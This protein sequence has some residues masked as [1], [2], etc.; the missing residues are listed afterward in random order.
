MGMLGVIPARGGSKG[1]RR[2]NLALLGGRPLIHYTLDAAVASGVL[3]RVIVSSDDQ[4]I[5]AVARQT[6]G[7]EVPFTRPGELARDD[8]PAIEPVRH[9][10]EW[11]EAEDGYAPDAVM[12]LQPTCPLRTARD[13]AEAA[14]V[15]GQSGKPSLISVS[16][17][18]QH[19]S[20]MI[21]QGGDGLAFCFERGDDRGRQ[22]FPEAWFLNGAIYI[23]D[24]TF[25]LETGT[26]YDLRSCAL[27]H[28]PESHSFDIDNRFD[29][30][31]TEGYLKLTTNGRN[32]KDHA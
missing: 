17:P 9:L 13:I 26:F 12:L 19:P 10:L 18:V 2:K 14:E 28:M 1:I 15:F 21:V 30:D 23:T 16:P 7:I 29:L 6:T 25:L 27:Y 8:T 3:E 20:D 22:D 5:I 24:R 32:G 4:E 11:L 31:V